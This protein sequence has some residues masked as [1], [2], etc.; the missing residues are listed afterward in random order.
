M[1]VEGAMKMEDR[2]CWLAPKVQVDCQS[3]LCMRVR[4]G[5]TRKDM[6]ANGGLEQ[7]L[8]GFLTPWIAHMQAV[9]TG[10]EVNIRQA[11]SL[12]AFFYMAGHKHGSGRAQ[13]SVWGN[14]QYAYTLQN[15]ENRLD[16]CKAAEPLKVTAL[17]CAVTVSEMADL[18]GR[19]NLWA[20]Q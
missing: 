9:S 2:W 1:G 7:G 6:V 14:L 4:G 12:Q 15:V 20:G 3:W 10:T 13:S 19:S 11:Q 5:Q 17:R 8:A 18:I 16:M